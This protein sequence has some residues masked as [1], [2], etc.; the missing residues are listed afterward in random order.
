MT[1]S[2]KI[3]SQ[4]QEIKAWD[5]EQNKAQ[6]YIDEIDRRYPGLFADM[7]KEMESSG[8]NFSAKQLNSA[9]FEKIAKLYKE[10]LSTIQINERLIQLAFW[11]LPPVGGTK[12][13]I[14]PNQFCKPSTE[15]GS[16]I[17]DR[18]AR[19]ATYY[20]RQA[21]DGLIRDSSLLRMFKLETCQQLLDAGILPKD[22]E[23]LTADDI[24]TRF[25]TVYYARAS[26]IIPQ[27]MENH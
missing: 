8:I 4:Y 19:E 6:A 16:E 1:I 2:P 11:V 14:D 17:I 27:E 26:A 9:E 13:Y 12:K 22:G 5:A 7:P 24:L 20:G 18:I 23:R 10:A 15:S 25:S 21:L 3:L